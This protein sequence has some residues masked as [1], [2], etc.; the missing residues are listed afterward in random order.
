MVSFSPSKARE[1]LAPNFSTSKVDT[2]II[3]KEKRKGK[4]KK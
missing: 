1:T 2:M 4:H 3:V